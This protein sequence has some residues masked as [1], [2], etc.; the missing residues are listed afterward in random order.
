MLQQQSC[1][2]S[3][4]A[5]AAAAGPTAQSAVH[6]AAQQALQPCAQLLRRL[7]FERGQL[8]GRHVVQPLLRGMAS[9]GGL[10]LLLRWCVQR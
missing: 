2:T 10:G 7:R 1:L 8:L 9:G 6:Q 3:A 4:A 5:A